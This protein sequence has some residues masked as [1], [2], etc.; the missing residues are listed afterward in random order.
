MRNQIDT[1]NL[2]T[3]NPAVRW[4]IA[5]PPGKRPSAA[6]PF[7]RRE[8]GLTLKEAVRAIRDANAIR[9]KWRQPKHIDP[10]KPS[11]A[12]KIAKAIRRK[13]RA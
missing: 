1:A 8:F 6:I 4:L 12:K 7:L 9:A 3:G 10:P 5:N 13:D 2:P 11:V